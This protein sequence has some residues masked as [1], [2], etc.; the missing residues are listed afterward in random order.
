M[1]PGR[2]FEEP[3]TGQRGH[4]RLLR[5]L[6]QHRIAA[7]DGDGE[8]PG[9]DGDREVERA[10]HAHR[11]E[12]MPGLQH[13]VPGTLRGDGAS[14]ELPRQTYRKVADVD[15]LLDFAQ[16]LLRESCR[17]RWSP[18]RPAGPCARGAPGELPDQ[19]TAPGG[20]HGSPSWRKA[21]WAR[22]TA[23]V[24]CI[25]RGRSAGNGCNQRC[26]RSGSRPPGRLRGCFALRLPASRAATPMSIFGPRYW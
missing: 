19:L 3:L 8:V 24:V 13:S 18:A 25:V 9:P 17:T 2:L 15:H 6:P 21:S 12:R 22:S 20:G 1:A 14:V 7:D 23:A 10:D 26:R 11:A 16:T 4:R 5:G